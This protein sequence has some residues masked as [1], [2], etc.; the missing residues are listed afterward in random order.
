MAFLVGGVKG[1]GRGA[2]NPVA[3]GGGGSAVVPSPNR[4]YYVVDPKE[5]MHSKNAFMSPFLAR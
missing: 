1:V 2:G 5:V 4:V 3:A